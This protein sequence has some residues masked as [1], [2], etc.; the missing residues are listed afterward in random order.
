MTADT[1]VSPP[2]SLHR[3]ECLLCS[4]QHCSLLSLSASVCCGCVEAGLWS[5]GQ[6]L[7]CLV[8]FCGCQLSD[9]NQFISDVFMCFR[10]SPAADGPNLQEV[11]GL[12]PYT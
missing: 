7:I 1:E 6:Q 3:R 11:S 9:V 4:G 8:V 5:D 10:C 12:S 2:D